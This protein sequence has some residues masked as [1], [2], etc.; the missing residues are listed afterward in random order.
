[1]SR[2]G[3][4]VV[5]FTVLAAFDTLTQIA[6]KLVARHAGPMIFS[7]HWFALAAHSVW[8]YAAIAG[9]LGAFVAWMTLLKHA[10]VGPAF[11]ASHIDVVLILVLSVPLFGERMTLVQIAG[12]LLIAA[13]ILLVSRSEA[14][15]ESDAH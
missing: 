6:F 14:R 7:A 2:T 1:V 8:T 4:Y 11:A 3:F 15:V 9:Y 5:G 12:A 13:G 10:P